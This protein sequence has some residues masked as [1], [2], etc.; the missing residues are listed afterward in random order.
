V[1]NPETLDFKP[2]R[3]LC[4]N[5]AQYTLRAGWNRFGGQRFMAWF[6]EIM[7]KDEGKFA[8]TG[9]HCCCNLLT[10]LHSQWPVV[11][12]S[13]NPDPFRTEL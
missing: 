8:L 7:S 1:Q 13:S 9:R 10:M 2:E 5:M 3:F 4:M 12:L 6:E 11:S